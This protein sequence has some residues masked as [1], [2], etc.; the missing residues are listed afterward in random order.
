[1]FRFSISHLLR[2]SRRGCFGPGKKQ[3]TYA[4]R[5][6]R[7]QGLE[8]RRVL[9]APVADP[10][11]TASLRLMIRKRTKQAACILR[12]LQLAIPHTM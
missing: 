8:D 4:A 5:I 11:A 2:R 7:I 9:S 10:L 3:R 1:M 6:L 12:L